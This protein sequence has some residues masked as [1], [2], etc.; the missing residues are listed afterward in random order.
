[1]KL[2]NR[3]KAIRSGVLC[4]LALCFLF[5]VYAP[6]E[7]YLGSQAD[8]WFGFPTITG[9]C[10]ILFAILFIPTVIILFI[11]RLLGK[12]PYSVALVIL[13]S[14]LISVYVQG[15]FFT[16][17]LP[18]LDGTA[19]N[20]GA[21]TLE[22]IKSYAVIAILLIASTVL[23]IKFRKVFLKS[24]MIISGGLFAML[25]IT[26][27]SLVMTTDIENKSGY[28]Q[29]TDKDMFEYS[30]D[31]NLIVFVTDAVDNEVFID[32]LKK[33][34]EFSD[35]FDDFTYYS[36]ALAGYPF[37]RDSLALM[38]SGQWNEN[39]QAFKTYAD[40]A[41][42][43][44]P[45][46]T[47]LRADNYQIGVYNKNIISFRADE[48]D[49]VI[50][51]QI[52]IEPYFKNVSSALTLVTKMAAIRYAPWDLKQFGY[53]TSE[54]CGLIKQLPEV[55]Y[56]DIKHSDPSFY[57]EI[58]NENP[59]TVTDDKCA[60]IIHIEGAHVP[61]RWDKNVNYTK[62]GTYQGNMEAT[63]TICAKYLERLKESGVYD[64]S[65]IVI[66]GDH[67]FHET[68]DNLLERMNPALMIK[69]IGAK[70]EAMTECK[71]PVSYEQLT[72]AFCG[73]LDKKELSEL[74]PENAYPNGRRLLKYWY[75]K[76]D[77]MYE[78]KVTGHAS[79]ISSMKETG[80]VYKLE[81]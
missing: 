74:F 21:Y 6:L 42:K 33:N 5:A 47:K 39:E 73:L 20:W 63:L 7:L 79:D 15:T 18:S 59:I 31:Q 81:Q 25:T 71:T 16:G 58:K 23:I 36:D 62:N 66:L 70:G 77:T 48:F 41:Y 19:I 17:A 51:N 75:L 12:T 46:L 43:S 30:S 3:F 13:F 37:T 35:T 14:A 44:S 61:L 60:R 65:V 52:S 1:M 27:V 49:G 76:E 55:E 22:R 28:L 45:L 54:Y 72:N 11:L 64:N 40:G 68:S 50:E 78:Y 29:P 57:Q 69:G 9:Y 80:T 53:D 56:G 10:L 34:P 4:A 32:T 8:F 67:G 38:L 26:L 24:V 2:K